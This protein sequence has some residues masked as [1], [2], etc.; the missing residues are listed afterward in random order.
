MSCSIRLNPK[1]V[2]DRCDLLIDLVS[3]TVKTEITP[4][5]FSLEFWE[6]E[7]KM[8]SY[9]KERKIKTELMNKRTKYL[10]E[11]FGQSFLNCT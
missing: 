3:E 4:N 2:Q 9:D 6:N 7:L 1:I 10:M 8:Y 5:N 11:K